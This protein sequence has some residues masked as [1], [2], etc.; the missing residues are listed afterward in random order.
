MTGIIFRQTDNGKFSLIGFYLARAKRIIPALAF[1]CLSLLAAGWFVLIP[2]EYKELGKHAAASIGFL[3][4]LARGW[5]LR[6]S[7]TREMATA[8][9]VS[10]C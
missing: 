10:V 4:I 8:H 7:I 3:S 6:H 1:L 9:L 2:S 5:I